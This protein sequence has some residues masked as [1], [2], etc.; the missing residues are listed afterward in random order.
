VGPSADSP[1]FLFFLPVSLRPRALTLGRFPPFY[2]MGTEF[3]D[4]LKF[5]ES[6]LLILSVLFPPSPPLPCD[7]LRSAFLF[8]TSVCFLMAVPVTSHFFDCPP[9]GVCLMS[10]ST[11]ESPGNF[12]SLDYS[13][14]LSGITLPQ[15]L[16]FPLQPKRR[17]FSFFSG[18]PGF[19]LPHFFLSSCLLSF[20]F[21]YS[22]FRAL[23][24]F[25]FSSR[26][27]PFLM[28]YPHYDS[29]SPLMF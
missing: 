5:Q 6:L 15:S 12:T 26:H 8:S 28:F 20:L 9:E 7:V 24:F 1:F 25:V 16:I 14:R 22:H 23:S 27:E 4:Y 3:P 2:W 10:P 18:F 19:L 17:P 21:Y 11:L 13:R 29:S